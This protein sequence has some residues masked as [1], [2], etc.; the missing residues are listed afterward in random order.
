MCGIAGCL[1]SGL[2]SE[3][4]EDRL[5][6][7]ASRIVHRGPDDAGYWY[8]A[9]AG[10]GL[11]HRRLAV[12]DLSRTGHQPMC[13]GSGRY[14][15]TYNGELYNFRELRDLLLQRGHSFRGSS[16]TEVLLAAVQAWGLPDAL[17]KFVGMFAFALWDRGERVLYLV[18]DRLGEKPLYYGWQGNTFLFGSE[19]KALTANAQWAGQI[20]RQALT[21]FLKY[22]YVPTPYSIFEGIKKLPPGSIIALSE[23]Q[24]LSRTL[25][26]PR[27][28]WSLKDLAEAGHSHSFHGSEGDVIEEFG[29]LLSDAVRLQMLADVPVGAFLSGGVDSSAIVSLMQS[30]ST[31]P[32][33]TF[34]IGFDEPS[35]DEAPYASKVARH[36]GTAHSELYVTARETLEVIPRLPEIYDEP[37]A[38]SSQIP[39][40]LISQLART[41]VTVSLSGDGGDELLGGYKRYE[42]AQSAWN[43]MKHF[44]ASFRTAFAHA[45]R[46][47]PTRTLNLLLAPVGSV[48]ERYGRRGPMGRKLRSLSGLLTAKDGAALYERLMS[49]RHGADLFVRG[50]SLEPPSTL[51]DTAQWPTLG[52]FVSELMCVDTLTYLPDDILVKVDRAAMAVSL[53]TRMPLLDHR[54]VEF[55]L[56]LPRSLKVRRGTSKWILRQV[57]DRHVPHE[58]INRPKM[59]FAMPI[60]EWLRGPL[61][62]WA[63][64][65]LDPDLLNRQAVL[66]PEQVKQVWHEHTSRSHNWQG[67]LW[68]LLVF[69]T[70]HNSLQNGP[71]AGLGASALRHAARQDFTRPR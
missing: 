44:P 19:L 48:S 57:L 68:N 16:D 4:W 27:T 56:K 29:E 71:R 63:E 20:D 42:L 18:R 61:R 31:R 14:I 52:D 2:S 28:Y 40:F 69:Q 15:V 10:V 62:E 23:A 24:T 59:G 64:D 50:V 60:D 35:Y 33:K 36:L 3:D 53:E 70:W 22:S 54:L 1:V 26:E 45:L 34:T 11:C 66:K 17:P 25:P 58:L 41:E 49:H 30:H 32:V 6:A 43:A 7:M 5:R 13:S 9:E 38:D 37:F 55:L 47:A 8:D 65:L 51:T 12:L 39:T 46:V 21:L 67:L